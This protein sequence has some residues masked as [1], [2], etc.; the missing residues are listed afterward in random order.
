[1][2]L[3]IPNALSSAATREVASAAEDPIPVL[4]TIREPSLSAY[5]SH[6]EY[7]YVSLYAIII[8]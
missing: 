2:R 8:T 4:A 5:D 3:M 6:F 7:V 1:M